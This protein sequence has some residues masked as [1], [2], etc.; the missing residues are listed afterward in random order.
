MLESKLNLDASI[1]ADAR[2]SAK[3][4]AVDVQSYIDEHST[5][6]VERTICRLLGIDGID[7]FEVPLPNIVVEH[8][9][10]EGNIALGVAH[11][12]GNAMVETGLSPQELAEKIS[13]GEIN[14]GKIS[15]H[16]VFEIKLAIDKIA[17]ENVDKIANN[18]K[19]REDLL[20]KYGDK[21][22]PLLYLIV[23]TGNIYEDI[24]QAVAAAKQGAD[25]IAV[26]RS[27]GQSLLDYVP[28]GAT[29]E[30]FGGTLATQEKLIS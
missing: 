12:I 26:I 16:D 23:A 17:R 8:I 25:I 6:A 7:S 28:Y 10:K 19:D 11:Y 22:G 24:T 3:N 9:E 29:T 13:A 4:I 1:V 20:E 14:L 30:G 18:R 21:Q 5:I 15:T 2:N 27:T